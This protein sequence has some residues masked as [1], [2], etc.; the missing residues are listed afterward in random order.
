ML[1][2]TI[3]LTLASYQPALAIQEVL[4]DIEGEKTEEVQE[5]DAITDEEWYFNLQGKSLRE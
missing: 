5:D 3:F 1:L 4:L 2:V